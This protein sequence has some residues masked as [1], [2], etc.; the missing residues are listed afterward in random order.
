MHAYNFTTRTGYNEACKII[1]ES[2]I[3]HEKQPEDLTIVTEWPGLAY[4]VKLTV[5]A[6]DDEH[7]G[8]EKEV[9]AIYESLDMQKLTDRSTIIIKG[10]AVYDWRL[11]PGVKL[12]IID[13]DCSEIMLIEGEEKEDDVS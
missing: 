7:H 13:L 5:L 1:D 8:E 3:D 4:D 9:K 12:R 6:M 2:G 11:L 10:G